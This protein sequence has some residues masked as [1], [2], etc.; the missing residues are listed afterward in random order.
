MHRQFATA[1]P[2]RQTLLGAMRLRLKSIYGLQARKHGGPGPETRPGDFR[3]K[4]SRRLDEQCFVTNT[5][6]SWEPETHSKLLKV[7][8]PSVVVQRSNHSVGDII[9]RGSAGFADAGRAGWIEACA[10]S[11]A[12]PRPPEPLPFTRMWKTCKSCTHSCWI[13]L[14]QAFDTSRN[15]QQGWRARLETLLESY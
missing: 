8:S 11:A 7:V 6:R 1:E 14:W 13:A 15:P 2:A 3:E 4:C 5:V 12:A 10:K 9:V